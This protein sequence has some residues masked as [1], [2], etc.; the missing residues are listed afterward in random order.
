MTVSML[1]RD[2]GAMSLRD[3]STA[4]GVAM[5]TL[6]HYFGPRHQVIDAIFEESLRLGRQGL[7]AQRCSEKP[8]NESV[9]DYARAL[10]FA[11]DNARDSRLGDLFAISL[12]EGL[13]D[14][15]VS[16]STL[17]HIVDP[18]IDAL[19]ERLTHHMARGEMVETEP[20]AAALMLL[21]PILLASLHQHQLHGAGE[22]PI[23]LER[24]ADDLGAAF[25][26]AFRRPS[27]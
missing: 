2:G 6:R 12:A 1:Q 14:S 3:L 8:F 16:T 25:V 7:D 10:V 9:R 27:A 21:S 17:K 23:P 11:L 22:R 4:A 19:V 15:K 13:L 26:R 18:T 24:L 5:P 20:R